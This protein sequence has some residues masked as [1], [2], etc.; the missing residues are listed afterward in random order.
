MDKLIKALIGGAI[1][2]YAGSTARSVV[3]GTG[4]VTIGATVA[5]AAGGYYL[6]G[7]LL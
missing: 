7:E 5:G 3:G 1:C 4:L 2:Y 6:A